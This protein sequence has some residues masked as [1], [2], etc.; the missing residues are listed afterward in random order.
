MVAIGCGEHGIKTV[1][2]I[3]SELPAIDTIAVTT[4]SGQSSSHSATDFSFTLSPS[5]VQQGWQF[6]TSADTRDL[7]NSTDFRRLADVLADADLCFVTGRL[8][9]PDSVAT[10]TIT[11]LAVDDSSAIGIGLLTAESATDSADTSV[12][13]EQLYAALD[14]VTLIDPQEVRPSTPFESHTDEDSYVSTTPE[15]LFGQFAVNAIL[16]IVEPSTINLDYADLTSIATSGEVGTLAAGIS[17]NG[18]LEPRDGQKVID[19]PLY[20]IPLEEVNGCWICLV[21]GPQLTLKQAEGLSQAISEHPALGGTAGVI[22][23]AQ[24]IEN[25]KD[26][27]RIYTLLTGVSGTNH[28]TVSLAQSE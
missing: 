21:G 17:K 1:E 12:S 24:I 22:W 11:A 5:T 27:L 18:Q 25:L 15:Y 4:D 20:P 26:E 6:E 10:T 2:H 9:T 7:Y 3:A 23:S 13:I 14:L 8:A 16:T 28:P 19:H